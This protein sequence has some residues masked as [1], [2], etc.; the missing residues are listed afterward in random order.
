[1]RSALAILSALVGPRHATTFQVWRNQP[2]P[3]HPWLYRLESSDSLGRGKQSGNQ[4]RVMAEHVMVDHN[5]HICP[6]V[7][8]NPELGV[9]L[10]RICE[11]CPGLALG[12]LC[13]LT[14]HGTVARA[15]VLEVKHVLQRRL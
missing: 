15:N 10:V 7:A 11:H 9:L 3:R 12:A 8:P 4:A 13:L 2:W 1:M 6:L 14:S 5:G